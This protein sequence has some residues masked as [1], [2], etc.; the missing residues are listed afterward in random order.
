MLGFRGLAQILL[1]YGRS[2]IIVD[3]PL[4]K[5]IPVTRIDFIPFLVIALFVMYIF[6][7]IRYR[8]SSFKLSKSRERISDKAVELI[9][10]GIWY[11]NEGDI[12]RFITITRVNSLLF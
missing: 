2:W 6:T 4:S 3:A 12:S 1:A 5:F 11:S 10:S 8:A 7:C 9:Q